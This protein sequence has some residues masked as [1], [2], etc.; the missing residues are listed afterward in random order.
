MHNWDAPNAERRVLSTRLCRKVLLTKI[1]PT[2][3][4]PTK[5][6]RTKILRIKEAASLKL[7]LLISQLIMDEILAGSVAFRAF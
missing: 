1:L 5:T 2:K 3:I 4:L 7:L 6:L